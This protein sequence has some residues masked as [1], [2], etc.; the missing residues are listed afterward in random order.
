MRRIGCIAYPDFHVLSLS[1]LSVFEAANRRAP[2]PLYDLH[3]LSEN[4][5]PVRT[6]GGL[7]LETE[8]LDDGEFDTLIVLG[9]LHEKPTFSA[10]LIGYLRTAPGRARRVASICTGALALAE[11]GVLDDR[12][13]TT[14]GAYAEYFQQRFPRVKLHGD[15]IFVIDGS[16]WTSAG[17]MTCIDLVLAMVEHDAGKELVRAVAKD[18]VIYHRRRGWQTQDSAMLEL[19]PDSDRI[20]SVL[21]FARRNLHTR[22]TVDEL[23]EAAHLS[24]RQF[25]RAFQHETGQSPAK[26]VESLR[27]ETARLM[28]E[29]GRHPIDLIARQA[30]FGN[31]ERMRR[32]FVRR[33]GQAPQEMRREARHDRSNGHE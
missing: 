26:A 18:L 7:S 31:R 33:F 16:I 19:E 24:P 23:A 25:R 11:A 9:T 32:A 29:A 21:E 30:G 2:E 10:G 3:I 14:H 20:Q 17:C 15:R 12:H 4:G 22:L 8:P 28:V 5:G 1:I 13:A 6:S 27:I